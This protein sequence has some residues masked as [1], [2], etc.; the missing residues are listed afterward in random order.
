MYVKLFC[1]IQAIECDD[2]PDVSYATSTAYSAT[3]YMAEVT[4][5]CQQ[6]TGACKITDLY[7]LLQRLRNQ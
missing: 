1:Y 2:P 4:Y 5:E 3:T 6:P 7:T